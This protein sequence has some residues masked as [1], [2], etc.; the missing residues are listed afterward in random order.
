MYVYPKMKS[1]FQ[2]HDAQAYANFGCETCH[3]ESGEANKYKMPNDLFGLPST[4]TLDA[5]H[6][7]D[8]EEAKFMLE[9]VL[10]AM[11]ELLGETNFGPETPASFTCTSCHTRDD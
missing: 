7:Y 5:A 11:A 1:I 8:A 9:K 3:G 6:D 2:G 4:G 10:P